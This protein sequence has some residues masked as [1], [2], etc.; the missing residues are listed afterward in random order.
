LR[1]VSSA[2]TFAAGRCAYRREVL[3][4]VV[5]GFALVYAARR[6]QLHGLDAWAD[7]KQRGYEGRVAKRE[8]SPY[9]S[10]P[11]HEWLKV[12][13][14]HEGRF[15]VVGLDVPIAGPS[16]DCAIG[17]TAM[18]VFSSERIPERRDIRR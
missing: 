16:P 13:Q 5:A 6:I 3:E 15:V 4:E 18:A 10:G 7:V 17:F 14:R 1:D 9:R 8:A 12:K 2:E 11:T